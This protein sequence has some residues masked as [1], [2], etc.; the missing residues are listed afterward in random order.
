ME[1]EIVP[2]LMTSSADTA[3]KSSIRRHVFQID[4]S[5]GVILAILLVT[6]L[7]PEVCQG[8]RQLGLTGF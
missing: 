7:H 3:A 5:P 4:A 8:R 1:Q 6:P 2:P